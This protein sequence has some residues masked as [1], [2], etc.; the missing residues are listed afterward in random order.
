VGMSS[1]EESTALP[2]LRE[3]AQ[4]AGVSLATA[5]KAL[6]GRHPVKPDTR[7]KVERAAARLGFRPNILAR[8]LASGRTGTIGLI[9]ND[10]D[11]RFSIPILMGA[12]DAFGEG[13]LN[14]LLSDARGD[15]F[16]ERHHL[17]RMLDR[18]VDGL[19][20]V[21]SR[22]DPRPPVG[23]ELPVPVV[24]VYA[25]AEGPADA[26]VAADNVL[27]GRLVTEHLMDLGRRN[28]A[29][30]GGDPSYAA[31]RDR[32]E[33]IEG[34]LAEA[35][36]GLAGPPMKFGTW[37]EAWGRAQM[38]AILDGTPEV[39][40]VICAS[41]QIARGALDTLRDRR[42]QVPEQV[43]VASF[44]NW[45]ILATGPRPQLTSLD[46]RFQEMGRLAAKF[47]F[48]AIDGRPH[49]GLA[50]VAGRLVV[51]GSTVQGLA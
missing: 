35:G 51:R 28:I 42:I 49:S 1:E 33:G 17:E 20:M 15:A 18:R 13:Q 5:S 50:L 34:R 30:I 4:A 32:V 19:L 12:E 44:D 36:L 27:A 7:E 9:T 31:A 41:D 48:D 40:A 14:I 22:T 38:D 47:L 26:S 3:V 2:T 8:D 46:M 29:H 16:R 37:S 11:G 6:T 10:L 24:Y 39:D 45:E 43:A 25:P 21:G 23:L